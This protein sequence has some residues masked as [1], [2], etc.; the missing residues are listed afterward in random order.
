MAL[1]DTLAQAIAQFEGFN[2]QGT[3]AQRNNNPGNLRASPYSIGTDSNGYSIFPD[4]QTGW[5][6]LYYQL[7]LY[8]GRGLTLD[9]M[10]NI[11]APASDNNNPSNYLNFVT[12]K[13][14]VGPSTSVSALYDS[15][16]SGN[17]TDVPSGSTDGS[18]DQSGFTMLDF[19]SSWLPSG[20]D[21]SNIG[22]G[23]GMGLLGIAAL[24]ILS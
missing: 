12:G 20:A 16:Q 7:S 6:A 9:Q 10:I 2:T 4:A 5:N 19:L 8:S 14:G 18:T 21:G 22:F 23:I 15:S 1:I 3:I 11:Y 13:L 17:S 24:V